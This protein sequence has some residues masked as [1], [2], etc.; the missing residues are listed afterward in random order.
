MNIY[1]EIC[2]KQ[3]VNNCEDHVDHEKM[4]HWQKKIDN[5]FLSFVPKVVSQTTTFS[6][7]RSNISFI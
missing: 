4:M 3:N 2:D 6:Y 1:N 5:T 7:L